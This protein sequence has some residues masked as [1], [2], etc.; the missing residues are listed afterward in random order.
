MMDLFLRLFNLRQAD[1]TTAGGWRLHFTT[2]WAAPVIV[3]GSLALIVLVWQ[4]YRRE[5]GTAG[6]WFKV[7]LAGFRLL[8]LAVL[9]LVL[10]GPEII[11]RRSGLKEA[12]VLILADKSDSMGLTDRYR[13]ETFLARLAHAMG[14]VE[15]PDAPLD[16]QTAQDIRDLSRAEI[17]NEILKDPAYRIAEQ[18]AHK[19][20]VREFVFASELSTAPRGDG[21]ART[22]VIRP[23]GKTTAIG[24]CIRDAAAKFKRQRIAAMIVLSDWQHNDGL[25]PA[26]ATRYAQTPEGAFPIFTVGAGDPTKQRDIIVHL[27]WAKEDPRVKDPV[28]FTV[29]IE[30]KGYDNQV[31]PLELH[32]GD[33]VETTDIRLKPRRKDGSPDQYKITHQFLKKGTVRCVARVPKREAELSGENNSAEYTVTV[34]D[35]K[36]RV[37]LLSGGPTWEW[38]YLKAALARDESV[39][40]SVWLQSADAN[41]VM[42]GG[43]QLD[44]LPLNKKELCDNYDVI[45]MLGA[46]PDAFSADQLEHV[47]SFVGDFGGGLAFSAGSLVVAEA[48]DKTPL[49]GCLPV[50]LTPPGG[51]SPTA[52]ASHSFQPRITEDGW[53]S[54]I[55]RLARDPHQN[56]ELWAALPGLFWYH[57]VGKIKP[58]ALVLAEHPTDK[59]EGKR[60]PLFVEQRYGRGRVFFSAT[61]ETWRWRF[62]IG[63]RYFYAFWRQIIDRLAAR[64]KRTRL[65]VEKSSYKVNEKVQLKAEAVEETMPRSDDGSIE[66]TVDIPGESPRRVKLSPVDEDGTDFRGSFLATKPGNYVAKGVLDSSGLPKTAP[67]SVSHSTVESNASRLDEETLRDVADKTDGE[68]FMIYEMDQIPDKINTQSTNTWNPHAISIWDSWGCLILFLIPLTCEWWLRK[69][70]LLT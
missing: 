24:A 54:T 29:T 19:C 10:L 63:D 14:R 16:P 20:R 17:A 64:T 53:A 3:F 23:D 25:R 28:E 30:Q 2:Q 11:A 27:L 32:V 57:P 41:W 9:V 21:A 52:T 67:F 5:K 55:T 46:S 18:I 59:S 22:L 70:R 45:V 42:A 38:R 62:I 36:A 61:D 7:M 47:K 34:R 1:L 8:A 44:Q 56:R 69:R 66:V 26:A 4:V 48:F 65:Y 58:G 51:F 37:L 50:S 49:A 40:T 39:V 12:Y 60:L 15:D 33:D 43:R 13:D 31:V 68:A 35:N 6:P